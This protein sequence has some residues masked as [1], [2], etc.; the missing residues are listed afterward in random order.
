MKLLKN[1]LIFQTFLLIQIVVIAPSPAQADNSSAC[2]ALLLPLEQQA[3]KINDNGGI[4]ELFENGATLRKHSIIGLHVD[5]K[6]NSLIETINYLC[7]NQKGLPVNEVA[8]QIVP[9]M[10]EMG[11]EGFI[12][13]Y[14][15]LSHSVE[16][17]EVWSDY[18][19]YFVVNHT[20]ELDFNLTKKTLEGA[21]KIF[22]RYTTLAQKINGS[23]D[24]EVRIKSLGLLVP[25]HHD[26]GIVKECKALT[27][28]IKQF[29]IIDPLLKQAHIEKSKI[30]YA[31]NL[32][33]GAEAM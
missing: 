3:Q 24:E 11:R 5:S 27:E 7:E 19:E 31:P 32:T 30:P 28:D 23:N 18:A 12:K 9:M 22:E 26:K 8:Y 10:K 15:A 14:L 1:F 20:R 25:L 21:Q 33:G 17:I 29:N 2:Y 6:I 4:W 16:E 13:Y